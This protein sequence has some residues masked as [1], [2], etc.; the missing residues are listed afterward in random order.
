MSTVS[1]ADQVCSASKLW[2]NPGQ[3]PAIWGPLPPCPHR[4]LLLP[5]EA[6]LESGSVLYSRVLL[7]QDVI[8]VFNRIHTPCSGM[9]V[10][11]IG[12]Q[13]QKTLVAICRMSQKAFVSFSS[14]K[15]FRLA[16]QESLTT[17][18]LHT[19]VG[20]G[21]SINYSN[22][23][24]TYHAGQASN[25]KYK[26]KFRFDVLSCLKFSDDENGKYNHGEIQ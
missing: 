15:D 10:L 8:D 22:F 13:A 9:M 14:I 17:R 7:A 20:I 25:R 6:V 21:G 1:P 23:D 5:D 2:V 19:P 4:V 3:S 12:A 24:K 16:L 11:N 18:V 26:Y